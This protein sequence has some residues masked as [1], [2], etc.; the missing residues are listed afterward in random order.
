[1]VRKRLLTDAE[2]VDLYLSGVDS[3]TV[4]LRAQCDASLVC[5]LVRAA[6]HQV[7]KRGGRP[8]LTLAIPLD[9]AIRLYDSGLSLQ[10][11]AE[12]A[13]IDRVTMAST[14]RRAG[15][16]IRSSQDVA[17]MKRRQKRP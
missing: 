16:R 1:V 2:I 9:Q 11:V 5:A 15:V 7:R 10:A 4:G 14:L 8:F 12:R 3:Y 6:G 17:A 13:G